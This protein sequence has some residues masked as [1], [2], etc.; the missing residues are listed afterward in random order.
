MGKDIA[1]INTA[2]GGKNTIMGSEAGMNL[3]SSGNSCLIGGGAGRVLTGGAQNTLIGAEC[4]PA[5][6]GGKDN[7]MVGYKVAENIVSG[8]NNVLMGRNAGQYL[9]AASNGNLCLGRSAGPNALTT[10]SNRVY[11]DASSPA[12]GT[13]QPQG[14]SSLIYG[15]QNDNSQN[16]LDFNAYVQIQHT[17]KTAEGGT[18]R[19]YDKYNV[20]G[21]GRPAPGAGNPRYIALRPAAELGAT[22]T[23]TLPDTGGS[24]NDVLKTDGSGNLS[25]TAHTKGE[26]FTA[27]GFVDVGSTGGSFGQIIFAGNGKANNGNSGN[28]HY[29]RMFSPG[30]VSTGLDTNLVISNHIEDWNGTGS[31]QGGLRA[32]TSYND[33][34]IIGNV[35]L[36]RGSGSTV[37]GGQAGSS[38]ESHSSYNTF[39]GYKSGSF[40]QA[41]AT[42]SNATGNQYNIS[43]GSESGQGISGDKNICIGC[44]TGFSTNRDDGNH[45]LI[46]CSG[47]ARRGADSLIYGNQSSAT[48]HTLSFNAEV[49]VKKTTGVSTGTLNVGGGMYV[50][51]TTGMNTTVMQ[52]NASASGYKLMAINASSGNLV[53]VENSSSSTPLVPVVEANEE[54]KLYS[55]SQVCFLPG[56]K[57]TLSN[58]IKINIEKLKKGDTLLSYKLDDMDP[59]TKSVDVLSWFSEDDTG[60]FTE[61]E[62]TNIW[63]DK[64]PGYII[65]NDN[66]HVTHEHLIFTKMDDEYTWLSA[67]EIRKGDIVFTD[68]GE[69]EEITKIEKVKE[70][71]TVYNL[72]VTSSAMNYFADSYLVHNASLCDECAAKN[73]KL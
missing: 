44:F 65:L 67:K 37:I 71:V 63:S 32:G 54:L 61:S 15:Q 6:A 64:S 51:D 33:T 46:D 45:L 29:W 58:N 17:K 59:Y 9:N 35:A 16:F 73:N 62:V 66:L 27:D 34:I 13:P 26:T 28:N 40:N 2:T 70:E 5:L 38:V 43:V 68:K 8:V 10:Q 41:Q 19:L 49:T 24:A 47:T 55:F 72:R 20:S 57:I 31:N 36:G 21:D 7:T 22:Y 30:H 69:Y 1:K 18:L 56:T 14:E 52:T 11:I 23:L 50:G 42:A 4:G 3:T 39:I 25:W 60:E 53:N 12:A 48:N